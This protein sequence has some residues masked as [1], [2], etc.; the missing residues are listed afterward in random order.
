MLENRAIGVCYYP[1]HWPET[2]WKDDARKMAALGVR[3]VRIGEFAWSRLE[4]ARGQHDF[5]WLE[6]AIETLHVAGL[7]VI[8]GT[9]TA[10]PPKWLVD[11]MPDMLPVDRF[12]QVR[13]FGSRRHCCFSHEGYK[14]ECA[15]IV[16]AMAE[17]F[18]THDAVVGWQ[19]D[20][21]YACHDTARSWS[22]PALSGFRR[23]LAE[24]YGSIERLNFAWGNVFWSMDYPDF[25]SVELPGITPS[26]H[27]PAHRMEFYRFSSDQIAEFNKLQVEILRRLS[28]G[29][30]IIH[31]FMGRTLT[32]DHF[33]V[34]ADLDVSRLGQLSAGLSGGSAGSRRRVAQAFHA[35]RRSGFPGTSS[36][37][38]PG[39]LKRPLVGDGTAT[40]TGE[41]GRPQSCA[42][43]GHGEALELGGLCP[44]G[45]GRQLFP[46]ASG[47]LRARTDACRSAA[48]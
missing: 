40:R 21:E 39:Y 10:T 20:N 38:L 13:G 30:D 44:R 34:G 42:A 6:R 26:E 31:N 35:H 43:S 11:E 41:L 33:K 1:E 9:P 5:D 2:V 32:F 18:G 7:K 46:L 3:Y 28:P 48:P 17:R 27:N 15:G 25:G 16:T 36:R 22:Q 8:L 45:R 37:P 4:P 12:G 19:V 29:R 47:T 24:K 23:W 14:R